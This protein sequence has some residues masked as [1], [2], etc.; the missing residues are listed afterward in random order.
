MFLLLL[1]GRTWVLK[2]CQFL[3][4]MG[5]MCGVPLA[6]VLQQ[7]NLNP[8]GTNSEAVDPAASCLAK[9]ARWGPRGSVLCCF[10][11]KPRETSGAN[12]GQFG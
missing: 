7:K 9:C 2:H 11:L 4:E 8:V 12:A 6:T 3:C 5:K 10:T 1:E